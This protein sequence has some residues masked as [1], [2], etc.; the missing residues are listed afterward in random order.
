MSQEDTRSVYQKLYAVWNDDDRFKIS[1][2]LSDV[3]ALLHDT[4]IHNYCPLPPTWNLLG[5]CGSHTSSLLQLEVL[6]N[7]QQKVPD[8]L[9]KVRVY[10]GTQLS[11]IIAVMLAYGYSIDITK[12]VLTIITKEYPLRTGVLGGVTGAMYS[13]KVLHIVLQRLFGTSKIGDLQRYVAIDALQADT[14]ETD[15]SGERTHHA[16]LMTNY[17]E[18]GQTEFENMSCVDICMRACAV[19]GY[20]TEY[21]GYL[22]GMLIENNPVALC[23]PRL[24]GCGISLDTIFCLNITD[25][26]FEPRYFDMESYGKAGALKWVP[27]IIDIHQL[28][29]REFSEKSLRLYLGDQVCRVDVVIP[30]D[31][32]FG[33]SEKLKTLGASSDVSYVVEWLM[34]YWK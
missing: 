18:N 29:R 24:V 16:K 10:S 2:V 5:F 17:S 26:D 31:V 14:H 34:R 22:S 27:H 1:S 12:K 20:F 4:K 15:R 28:S 25:G 21:Q 8:V 11:S 32:G 3:D 33:D 9:E 19:P 6:R 13:N 7:V 30:K 23:L